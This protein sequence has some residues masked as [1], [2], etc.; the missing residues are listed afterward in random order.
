MTIVL[1]S[2]KEI[3]DLLIWTK[4]SLS[5]ANQQ[6]T[7]EFLKEDLPKRFD[8]GNTS[9]YGYKPNKPSYESMKASKY[10]KKPQLVATGKL[11]NDVIN[12]YKVNKDG[13][14][15]KYPVYGKYLIKRGKDFTK[16]RQQD[17]KNIST[18]TK[19]IILNWMKKR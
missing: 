14:R 19:K 4:K 6:A 18:R 8:Y 2:I 5:P 12:N 9:K 10:G 17:F 11:K 15:L 16:M 7:R 13:I 1:N 3:Q